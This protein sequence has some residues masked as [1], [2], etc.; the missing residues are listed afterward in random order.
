MEINF[1]MTFFNGKEHIYM[2]KKLYADFGEKIGGARKD[3]WKARGLDSSDLL[4]M[5]SYE[6]S[7]LVCKDN[8]WPK[9]D[10]DALIASGEKDR[11]A[12]FVI[13]QIRNKLPQKPV[14]V[15]PYTSEA[16]FEEVIYPKFI[17]ALK[18]I[19]DAVMA[20]N[21]KFDA[22]EIK[23]RIVYEGSPFLKN[24]TLYM[25]FLNQ[26]FFYFI[27]EFN[28]KSL[29]RKCDEIAYGIPKDQKSYFLAYRKTEVIK[30]DGENTVI[31]Q[32]DEN[33]VLITVGRFGARSYYY[34]RDSF[35]VADEW[36]KDTY[37]VL[38]ER[39]C[40]CRNIK[41]LQQAETERVNIAKAAA[42]V[43]DGCSKTAE[44]KK[45]L[46]FMPPQLERIERTGSK[47][48][49]KGKNIL[50]EDMINNFS[51]RGGEFGNWMNENDAK[52]S[53]NMCFDANIDMAKALNIS[54]KDI[55][56]GGNLAIAF[57]SRGRGGINAASAHFEPERN[58]IN[59]TKMKGAGSYAHEWGH[60]LDYYMGT[61]IEKHSNLATEG[62]SISFPELKRLVK[63]MKYKSEEEHDQIRESL[64]DGLISTVLDYYE[65][66]PLDGSSKESLIA[67]LEKVKEAISEKK[68][69]R[70][71]RL[72]RLAI[73]DN[74]CIKDM[75]Y[76]EYKKLMAYIDPDVVSNGDLKTDFYRNSESFDLVYSKESHGYWSSTCEM[77]ARS[78]AC[79]VKDKLIA[80]G[81][82][83]DYL[84]GHSEHALFVQDGIVLKAMPVG[85][86]R[87]NINKAFD[88]LFA[89]LREMNLVGSFDENEVSLFKYESSFDSETDD[90]FFDKEFCQL[91]LF[92][93]L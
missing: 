22:L 57:G 51:Y 63:I 9:P 38:Y 12:V 65:D 26:R 62:R 69:Y 89:K 30:Y 75:P 76:D 17:E 34:I 5:T 41:T 92:D 71:N 1:S 91:S 8:I 32:Y 6:K 27:E 78:F 66:Y 42:S 23:K 13:N 18:F 73:S 80:I 43:S 16:T 59:L 90:T 21:N 37:F 81:I 39:K 58:V 83:N 77:L 7:T 55:S 79:Y 82:K 87:E 56:L 25:N 40:L 64:R 44:K 84:C 74:L 85:R 93:I 70:V 20:I 45:K 10:Y 67:D 11:Y 54:I 52:W 61:S 48:Y 14:G 50:G 2:A 53:L 86:E 3:S 68:I 72:Y 31:S 28:I 33:T 35:N 60:A 24:R 46:R 36:E 49:R 88:E 4:S 47:D 29:I 19:R 15:S